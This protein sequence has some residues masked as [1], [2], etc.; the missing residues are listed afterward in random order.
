MH[1]RLAICLTRA[2]PQRGS[3]AGGSSA[4]LALFRAKYRS[5]PMVSATSKAT[6][7]IRVR[8]HTRGCAQRGETVDDVF[9]DDPAAEPLAAEPLAPNRSRRTAR[10]EPL[11]PNR[12]APNHS[13]RTTHAEP[14]TPTLLAPSRSC[15]RESTSV[16]ARGGGPTETRSGG[17][18]ARSR[19]RPAPRSVG[20][21]ARAR[22]QRL[23][24]EASRRAADCSRRY[25][26]I[27]R[28]RCRAWC[29]RTRGGCRSSR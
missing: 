1:F 6:Q 26:A 23:P 9:P 19:F 13:R 15:R 18:P 2:S 12:S 25:R 22:P 3:S 10:A 27:A 29:R 16:F 8:Y 4:F 5:R 24:G 14:L 17:P 7:S 11:A 21:V 28:G 20:L